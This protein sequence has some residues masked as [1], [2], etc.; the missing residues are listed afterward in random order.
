M[1]KSERKAFFIKSFIGGV[2][3][4]TISIFVSRDGFRSLDLANM[5]YLQNT[6]TRSLD[7]PF[8]YVTLIGSAEI[9]TSIIGVIFITLLI[10][11]HHM[12]TGIFLYILIF[13]IELF[14]KL[15]IYHPAPPAVFYRYALGFHFPS[16]FFVHTNFSYPSGHM[17]RIVFLSCILFILVKKIVRGRFTRFVLRL[18]IL[19]FTGVVLVSRIYLGEHWFSDVLG[20]SFL[21][22]SLATLAFAFW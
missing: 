1:E 11:K 7:I 8:S 20:G 2:L 17:A 14:G 16:S 6:L 9:V 13:V 5:L 15:F 12:F 4:L 10:L 3:L 18:F 22:A 19:L 21:G